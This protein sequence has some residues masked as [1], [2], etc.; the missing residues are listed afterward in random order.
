MHLVNTA[1]TWFSPDI[2]PCKISISEW[3]LRKNRFFRGKL[4]KFRNNQFSTFPQIQTAIK[5]KS[6]AQNCRSVG[7]LF[8]SGASFNWWV[9][10]ESTKEKIFSQIKIS[11]L[12]INFKSF[13]DKLIKG[14]IFKLI[15]IFGFFFLRLHWFKFYFFLQVLMG[16]FFYIHSV[17]LIEDLPLNEKYASLEEFYDAANAAYNQV[18][19]RN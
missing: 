12:V 14:V 11:N 13:Q 10:Y 17:A 6:V 4:Q 16:L 9:D 8:P 19:T 1:V 2:F 18:F 5:W 7:W 3:R 15:A